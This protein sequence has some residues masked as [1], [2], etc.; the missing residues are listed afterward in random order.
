MNNATIQQLIKEA[1]WAELKKLVTQP[2]LDEPTQLELPAETEDSGLPNGNDEPPF[3]PNG[4][5]SMPD[6]L[7]SPCGELKPTSSDFPQI[8]PLFGPVEF[9]EPRPIAG[10]ESVPN[11]TLKSND[12]SPH[13]EPP[14]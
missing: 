14:F 8:E 10:E 2:S 6:N 11:G 12:G 4:D 7:G 13:D 9:L 1:K 3:M 5:E